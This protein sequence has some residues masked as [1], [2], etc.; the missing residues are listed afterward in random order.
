MIGSKTG[1]IGKFGV[2]MSQT[3]H[4]NAFSMPFSKLPDLIKRYRMRWSLL[5]FPLRERLTCSGKEATVLVA[6]LLLLAGSHLFRYVRYHQPL[7]DEDYYAETDSLFRVLSMRADSMDAVDTVHVGFGAIPGSI[8]SAG[9]DVQ[10]W[11]LRDTLEKPTANFPIDIND[12][13]ARTFQ[14]L[15]RIGPKM[16]ERIVQF[17]TAKGSFSSIEELLDVRGIGEKTL[18]QLRPLIRLG[19]DLRQDSTQFLDSTQV[20]DSTQAPDSTQVQDP[21]R[22][23]TGHPPPPG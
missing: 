3:I 21:L 6:F 23:Q 16:A 17:R 14:A 12:A 13:D 10:M 20:L 18:E 4:P 7:F 19:P 5:L 9:T 1:Y 8:R 2:S 22:P 11:V 15:P